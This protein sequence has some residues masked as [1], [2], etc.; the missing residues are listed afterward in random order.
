MS[1]KESTNW[2][3]LFTAFR[4]EKKV[5]AQLDAA[6]IANSL[7]MKTSRIRWQHVE[8]EGRVPAVSRCIFVRICGD[9][10]GRLA[11]VSSLLLPA[12]F[13]E[14]RL[15]AEQ[16]E[17][18]RILFR[19]DNASVGVVSTDDV[20]GAKVQVVSGD[21]QGLTGELLQVA[22]SCQILVRLNKMV[23]LSINVTLDILK[24][25]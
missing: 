19:E 20:S 24:R 18:V 2:Y 16:M 17:N 15:P 1:E 9:D 3:L 6:E 11:T 4:A 23:S 7:P 12:D 21:F 10:L 13:S 5:K 25:V 22:D 14:C 8:K